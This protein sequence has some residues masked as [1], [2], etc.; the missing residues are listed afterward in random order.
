MILD[1][2]QKVWSFSPGQEIT[3]ISKSEDSLSCSWQPISGPHP[4]PCESS[5]RVPNICLE[6]PFKT[7][8]FYLCVSL[9]SGLS[10]SGFP[11]LQCVL[12]A[13]LTL[14]DLITLIISGEENKL[15]ISL[16]C[17][18]LQ[19]CVTFP[20]LCTNILYNRRDFV[21]W[22]AYQLPII[23][24]DEESKQFKLSSSIRWREKHEFLFL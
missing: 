18:F 21:Y 1:L 15:W 14:L 17:N 19:P 7:C 11:S 5:P 16:V 4:K 2:T 23:L 22:N 8:T 3:H 24:A 6:H 9:L 12:H 10:P 20:L 13:Q